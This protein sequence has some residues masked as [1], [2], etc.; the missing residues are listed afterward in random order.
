MSAY[1]AAADYWLRDEGWAV[2][3]VV[4]LAAEPLVAACGRPRRKSRSSL[5]SFCSQAKQVL[6]SVSVP[7][8]GVEQRRIMTEPSRGASGAQA[9]S[10]LREQGPRGV[11]L[12]SPHAWRARRAGTRPL[13]SANRHLRPAAARAV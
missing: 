11:Q 9:G 4:D 13:P 7:H 1:A 3:A 2:A 10:V 12:R 5:A 6:V 8:P